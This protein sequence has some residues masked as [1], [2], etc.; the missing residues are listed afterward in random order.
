MPPS[1]VRAAAV[2][3]PSNCIPLYSRPRAE[4]SLQRRSSIQPLRSPFMSS[5]SIRAATP[6]VA[7][8]LSFACLGSAAAADV[9]DST[10]PPI[11]VTAQ[12]LDEVRA[13]IQ[14][15]TGASTYTFN[16]AAIT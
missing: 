8:A 16:S 6:G 1:P 12:H 5:F 14:T 4:Q 3:P 9:D 7:A 11:V 10:L 13:N 15:E 2:L